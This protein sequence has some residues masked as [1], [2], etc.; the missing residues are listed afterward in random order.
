MDYKKIADVL[1]WHAMHSDLNG[2]EARVLIFLSTSANY[3]TA[4][5]AASYSE[6]MQAVDLSKASVSKA[7]AS[8]VEK[9]A[10]SVDL[11]ASGRMQ[12][13]YRVRSAEDLNK[14][15]VMDGKNPAHEAWFLESEK[16]NDLLDEQS[17]IGLDCPD[18]E[19][20]ADEKL[21]EMHAY[22]LGVFRDTLAFREYQIWASDNPA[23]VSKIQTIK[24][25]QVTT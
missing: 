4:K 6:L 14:Y 13:T 18:C 15:F 5:I 17:A 25:K 1:K 21:C 11:A 7:I 23:P 20:H 12:A 24:G 8:L 3:R 10:L 19:N 2:A 22:K 16:F 9:K